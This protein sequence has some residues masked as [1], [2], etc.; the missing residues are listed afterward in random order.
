MANVTLNI[1]LNELAW[2]I[3]SGFAA[4]DREIIGFIKEIDT[5]RGDWSF[6][7]KLYKHFKKEMKRARKD[8]WTN[9]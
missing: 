5:L 2:D 9:D 8:G 7:N 6:T 4:T 3:T 1:D